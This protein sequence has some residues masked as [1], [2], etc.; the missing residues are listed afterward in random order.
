MVT[1]NLIE[2][3]FH[4]A[5]PGLSKR[6]HLLNIVLALV[7]SATNQAQSLEDF[8][9]WQP[10]RVTKGVQFTVAAI[11]GAL[12]WTS[13]ATFFATKFYP[14]RVKEKKEAPINTIQYH[15]LEAGKTVARTKRRGVNS[16]CIYI[17]NI[18]KFC[19]REV[20]SIFNEVKYYL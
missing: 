15:K 6:G 17:V 14:F 5:G 13:Y 3:F 8:G 9:L 18:M 7:L 20:Y 2:I 11:A 1:C 10:N 16:E 12:L 19:T 4:S